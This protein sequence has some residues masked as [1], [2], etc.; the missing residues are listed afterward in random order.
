MVRM[1]LLRIH[2]WISLV[3]A[4]PLAVV[5]VT[6]LILSFE[7]MAIG[8]K[9]APLTGDT[10]IAIL[11]KHDPDGRARAITVRGYANTVSIGGRSAQTHIDLA[12]GEKLASPG[13][14]ADLFAASRRLH[15]H[16][17]FDLRWL[18]TA[19]TVAMLALI[20]LGL[21]MGWPRLRNSLAGWHKGTGWFLVPLLIASPLTGLFLAFGIT[22]APPPSGARTGAQPTNLAEAVRVVGAK[23]DLAQVNWIRPLGPRLAVRVNDRGEMRVF[24][25]TRDGLVPFSRNWPRLIHEGNWSGVAAPTINVV[26]SVA[27][28]LLLTTGLWMWQRRRFR[29]M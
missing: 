15:E 2:R 18:V 25:V 14:L 27:L 12:T 11:G 5:I 16:L 22:F 3:F 6:G 4:I 9:T 10:L 13:A 26:I 17:V 7:P 1:W 21:L 23:Y 24:T 29:L 8:A 19:S 28:V 20:P